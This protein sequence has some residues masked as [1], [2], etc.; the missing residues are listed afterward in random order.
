MRR[1]ILVWTLVLGGTLLAACRG[2]TLVPTLSGELDLLGAD[3]LTIRGHLTFTNQ[4]GIRTA[5]L[6]FDT[7]YHWNDSVNTHLR[8]V[9]LTVFTENGSERAHLVSA[10][11]MMDA[12]WQRLTARGNVVLVIAGEGRRL[13]S[14]ELNFD[15]EQERMWSDSAF[16]MTEPGR[17]PFR[18]R[19]F[20][21]D[22]EF[23]N[24][25]ATGE[26]S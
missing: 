19:S 1:V 2:E 11:G 7:A 22:L 10:T 18:G 15:P 24:F 5:H 3:G 25:Q 26:G 9:D 21:S 8:G 4:E 20:T 6:T 14:Q 12:R 23:N 13:E 17:A 16:V